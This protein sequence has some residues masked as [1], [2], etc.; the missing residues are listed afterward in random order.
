MLSAPLR[1]QADRYWAGF[2][3]CPLA[4]LQSA[5]AVWVTSEQSPGLVALS[6]S[7][8]DWIFALAPG[9]AAESMVPFAQALGFWRPPEDA[10][11][12]PPESGK[13]ET[14]TLR[15]LLTAAGLS[16]V[17]GPAQVLYCEAASFRA[18]AI[19]GVRQLTAD[20]APAVAR[21][22][23]GIGQLAWRLD[24]PERWIA[25]FGLFEG[26]ALIAAA[27]VRVWNDWIGEI[28]VDTLP[29]HR[30]RGHARRLTRA[31]THWLLTETALLPQ[32][33][34]ELANPA[35]LRVAQ[36]VGYE[37]YGWLVI[38]MES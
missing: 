2:L 34:A 28:F 23:T 38:A 30:R 17:Y 35:S 7:G 22:R 31:A 13:G 29:A 1:Q 33:D 24:D 19:A 11:V 14:H 36:A 21:F 26:D 18:G 5:E 15:E 37:P 4:A 16:A 10:T 27:A 25:A 20:D 32:Y 8:A 12:P 3:G 9:V 6:I